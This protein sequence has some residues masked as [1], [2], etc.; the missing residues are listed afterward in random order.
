MSNN[1]QHQLTGSEELDHVLASWQAAT[2]NEL[3][4]DS[5]VPLRMDVLKS[6]LSSWHT[7]HLAKAR[8]EAKVE[9]LVKFNENGYLTAAGQTRAET[10]IQEL[11][12]A[13]DE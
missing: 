12:E 2:D 4:A 8:L 7:K 3:A 10:L 5:T 13:K 6:A 1:P 11:S 9:L